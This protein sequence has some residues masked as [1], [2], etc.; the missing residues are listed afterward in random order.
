MNYPVPKWLDRQPVTIYYEDEQK[1]FLNKGQ[2][3]QKSHCGIC[4]RSLIEGRKRR[5]LDVKT[6][7]STEIKTKGEIIVGKERALFYLHLM[8]CS[9]CHIKYKLKSSE[10]NLYMEKKYLSEK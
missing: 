8:V 10:E 6:I 4:R 5:G 2:Y 7:E 9:S 1:I 3:I